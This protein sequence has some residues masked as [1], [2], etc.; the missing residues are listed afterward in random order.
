MVYDKPQG[1]KTQNEP[2]QE[3]LRKA[4]ER[5]FRPEYVR[6]D[7][8]YA[9]LKNLKLIA[10]FGWFFLTRLKRN[11]RVNPDRQG[12]RPI[13]EVEIPPEGRVVHRKGFG[14]VRVFR[15]VSQNGDAEYWATND[16]KMTE[17]K[18]QE[19]ERKGWGIEVYHRGLKQCC[20][21]ERAEV[22]KAVSILGHLLCGPFCGWR[23]I[24]CGQGGQS[25]QAAIWLIV[26]PHLATQLVQRPSCAKRWEPLPPHSWREHRERLSTKGVNECTEACPY[27][28]IRS[29]FVDG[30]SH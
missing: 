6:M 12:N 15:T 24:G 1:G 17:E 8:W 28:F 4:R 19:L 2:F 11:R 21:V 22:R 16:L 10:S 9:S 14:L 25:F 27:S 23:R 7:S 26:A 18:R 30:L 3:M 20:G 13:R 29:L 5:G